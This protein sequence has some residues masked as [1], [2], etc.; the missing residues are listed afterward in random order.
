MG[1]DLGGLLP[2]RAQLIASACCLFLAL[3]DINWE[4]DQEPKSRKRAVAYPTE[5]RK[6]LLVPEQEIHFSGSRYVCS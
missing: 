6:G 5:T 2:P 3:N 1:G 4:E